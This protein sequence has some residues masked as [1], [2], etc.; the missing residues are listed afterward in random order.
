MAV[1][2]A[3]K[4]ADFQCCFANMLAQTVPVVDRLLPWRAVAL[5]KAAKTM[6]EESPKTQ[7]SV[8]KT[9]GPISPTF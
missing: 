1:L 7:M 3:G 9:F 6:P 2:I 8:P 4:R 5:A